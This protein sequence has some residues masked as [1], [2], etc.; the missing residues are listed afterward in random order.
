MVSLILLNDSDTPQDATPG[1][2]KLVVDGK[3]LD[4]SAV[5]FGNG[6]VPTG[7][8]KTLNPGEAA[9]L[10]KDLEADR[11]FAAARDYK[12]S[13]KGEGFQSPTITVTVPTSR[14]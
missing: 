9:E 10:R 8:W 12:L 3:E 14:D 11:Y 2:W 7:G 4:D 5:I 6:P 1:L 13:W